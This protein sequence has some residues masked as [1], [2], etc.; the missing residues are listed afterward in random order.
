MEHS[1]LGDRARLVEAG[2]WAHAG[3][4]RAVSVQPFVAP[5]LGT[6]V[7]PGGGAVC[8][9]PVSEKDRRHPNPPA[10]G[11][12]EFF[13]HLLR[14]ACAVS[15]VDDDPA[16]RRTDR[17]GMGDAPSGE[18]PDIGCDLDR[19]LFCHGETIVHLADVAGGDRAV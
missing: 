18:Q 5:E 11:C 10:H 7:R 3:A 1:E 12:L 14:G 8:V 4:S 13:T 16:F 19:A 15:R 9:V 6:V 2:Q 17:H